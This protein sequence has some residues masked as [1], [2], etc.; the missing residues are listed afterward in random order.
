MPDLTP[1]L[2]KDIEELAQILRAKFSPPQ[3]IPGCLV[4]SVTD[5]SLYATNNGWIEAVCGQHN[6]QRV[7]WKSGETVAVNDYIDVLYFPDRRLFEAYGLGGTGAISA[8]GVAASQAEVDAGTEAAKYVSPLTLS[9]YPPVLLEVKN[10]SGFTVLPNAVGY[11]VYTAAAG[12][13][14]V[15]TSTVGQA[16]VVLVG[17]ANNATIKV[18]TRGRYPLEY[19][20]ATPAA[21]DFLFENFVAV[22]AQSYMSPN[23]IA[24]AMAA[25][26]GGVV[27]AMML[28]GSKI[29]PFASTNNLLALVSVSASDFV[30]TQNGAP[31]GANITYNAP[32]SGAENTINP[33]L[34]TELGKIVIHNTT[35]GTEAYL[36]AT[37]TATNVMTFTAAGDV[38]GWQ[39]GDTLTAR[40]QT[41]TDVIGSAYFYD[42][43]IT[44]TELPPLTTAVIITAQ[45]TDTA[46]SK[47]VRFHPWEAGAASKRQVFPT[48][49]A[50][51]VLPIMTQPISLYK[52]R[53]TLQW[54]ANGSGTVV[55][56]PLRLVGLVVATP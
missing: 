30:C 20:G 5:V 55:L 33:T 49:V 38:S 9:N 41:N 12:L 27:D 6:Q 3:F 17:G 42:I 51:V 11:V 43:A 36:Q 25:G 18:A 35:R 40:S 28:T 47:F 7:R 26:A 31:S 23:V 46:A 2:R 32:S 19:I 10:T 48:Q 8:G 13:E 37:N 14:F 54:D 34:S 44:S 1:T 39:N 45:L 22:E 53:F 15:Y 29:I 56:S 24:I 50:S 16:C 21:G 4:K 52:K